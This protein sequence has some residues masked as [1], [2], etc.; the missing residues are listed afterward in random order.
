MY[1]LVIL[2][3]LSVRLMNLD[4]Y[5]LSRAEATQA[6]VALD[7]F[8]GDIP[9]EATNYSPLLASLNSLN[10]FLFSPSDISARLGSVL[11]GLMLVCLPI[12]L[13]R[14]LGVG[15]A[16]TASAIFALSASS[17][18]WSR[19]NV[20]D[21][22]VA[23]GLM[24]VI[25]GL[26][27]WRD[28]NSVARL[29]AGIA[30]LVLLLISAPSGF[31]A[32]VV[33]LICIG[34]VVL[35]NGYTLTDVQAQLSQVGLSIGQAGLLSVGLMI[36]L[37]TAAL[38]NLTGLAAISDLVTDWL[39]Q[40]GLQYQEGAGYPALLML[41]FYEPVI[42]IF[43]LIGLVRS[44][45]AQHALDRVLVIG[46]GL[47]VLIDLLMGGR[48]SGQILVT[49]VPLVLLASRSIADLLA[50]LFSSGKLEAEGLFISFGAVLSVFVYISFTS[51]TKCIESQAGC[52]TA[53]L[54]PAAGIGLTLL[55]AGIFWLWYGPAAA[56]RGLGALLLVVV[57]VF[58]IGS[59]W[60]LSFGPLKDLPFQPMVYQPASTQLQ[61]L[62]G[63][64]A[65]I[66]T[67]RTGE[68]AELDVALVSLEQPVLNWYLR[69]YR[70]I[71]YSGNF[72]E[73]Q[74]VSIVVAPPVG[75]PLG[76]GYVGQ[77]L[78]LINRWS[79]DS[80]QGKDWLRWYVF[81][82]LPNQMP[83]SDRIILWVRQG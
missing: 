49:L 80:I 38:F 48:S 19:V 3:A 26:V 68:P 20:G 77:D 28:H 56:W 83:E 46:F 14:E 78:S 44:F 61:T 17:L 27:H 54:L 24:L 4:N 52:S 75:E 63:D 36:V 21:I 62:I 29:L 57:S 6:L 79:P 65:R 73:A 2:I 43:G 53:W 58:S 13:R 40:F 82:L 59:S 35:I 81:R 60:R 30:G 10:F 5:P 76:G 15:G 11:L 50:D 31:T 55:L 47:A 70:N 51:W 64:I 32:L 9:A 33:L 42:V 7:I 67:E 41:L 18:Y 66:S 8:H 12:S 25:I 16:L 39:G 45:A 1:V 71:R 23:V 22:G 34:Y 37:G 74:G 69:D 72:A